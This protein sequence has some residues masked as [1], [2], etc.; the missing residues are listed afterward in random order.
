MLWAWVVICW[1]LLSSAAWETVLRNRTWSCE[2]KKSLQPATRRLHVPYKSRVN[3]GRWRRHSDNLAT[4]NEKLKEY[5]KAKIVIAQKAPKA[6]LL[7]KVSATRTCG[8]RGRASTQGSDFAYFYSL[9]TSDAQ[10]KC[11]GG[12]RS[13]GTKRPAV[14]TKFWICGATTRLC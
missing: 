12:S 4:E 8:S 7:P 11:D 2:C 10:R 6:C 14:A 5:A 9:A 1:V 13:E 3:L